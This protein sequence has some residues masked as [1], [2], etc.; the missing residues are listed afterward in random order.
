MAKLNTDWKVEPHGKLKPVSQGIWSVDGTITMPLGKFPRRMTVIKLA[1]GDL[2][3]WS[4]I[5]LDYDEMAT[6]D[7][8]GPVGFLIVP[9]AGHRLD[10][11]AWRIRYPAAK[12]VAPPGAAKTVN[13]A[14]PVDATSNV[15]GD[16]SIKFELVAGTKADEF[17]LLV[18]R[19][20]G[21]TLIINDILSSVSHPQGIG[22]NIMARL[23]GFGV[24]HPQTS[25]LV[26]RMY[27][28]D[29]NAV[30]QQFRHWAKIPNLRRIIVSHV[31]IIAEAPAQV[32]E[33]AAHEL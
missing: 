30:A 3:V 11:A 19:D 10:L 12:I 1:G 23:F 28:E 2:A 27:V 21:V 22:A 24:G 9:N 26:R 8:L 6:L 18:T 15:L 29:S 5:S 31:D 13:E 25:R 4:P 33:I 7:A 17:A 32:L 14:A 20:D 16:P